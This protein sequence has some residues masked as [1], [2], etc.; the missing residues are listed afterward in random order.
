MAE[1]AAWSAELE[2]GTPKHPP[3]LPALVRAWFFVFPAADWSYYLLAVTLV[4][5]AIYFCWL[6]AGEFLDGVKRAVVPFFLMLIPF[7]NFLALKL[8]HNVVLIP[9]WAATTFC[10]VKAYRTRAIS[11]AIATGLCA[12][13]A[14]LAKYWSFFLLAGLALAVLIG[15]HRGRSSD[16][17]RRS[18]S[19]RCRSAC[20]CRTSCG[21]K[22]TDFRRS[23]M[24][25]TARPRITSPWCRGCGATRSACWAISACR[26]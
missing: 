26:S 20:S 23:S 8:D 18:S 17:R 21:W 24:R 19:R 10:F 1:V 2:W 12:G 22:R 9:L 5:V 25:G 3:L 6:L 7:Y 15:P 14:V 4:T 11:W 16:R 13:L